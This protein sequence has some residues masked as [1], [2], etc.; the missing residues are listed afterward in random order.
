M[1]LL[2]NSLEQ[3]ELLTRSVPGNFSRNWRRLFGRG[4]DV[5]CGSA[6][7]VP[8]K[9]T[10]NTGRIAVRWPRSAVVEGLIAD[11]MGR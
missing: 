7:R 5:D 1:P 2:V 4:V 11:L 10:A 6:H 3:A 9:V 8:L